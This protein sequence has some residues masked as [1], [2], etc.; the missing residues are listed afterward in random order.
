MYVA[1]IHDLLFIPISNL[2]SQK[3]GIRRTFE[4]NISKQ[5]AKISIFE[6]IRSKEKVTFLWFF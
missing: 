1:I 5:L 6:K 3:N 2:L 4:K